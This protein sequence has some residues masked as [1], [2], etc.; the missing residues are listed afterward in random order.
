MRLMSVMAMNSFV[1]V[2]TAAKVPKSH[3]AA[4]AGTVIVA[5]GPVL[6]VPLEKYIVIPTCINYLIAGLTG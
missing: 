2:S 4:S 6:A 3:V 1:T 5:S